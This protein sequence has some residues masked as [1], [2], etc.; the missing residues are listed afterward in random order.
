MNCTFARLQP[1]GLYSPIALITQLK[2]IVSLVLLFR[3]SAG[4]SW[5]FMKKK[6]LPV[7][8]LDADSMPNPIEPRS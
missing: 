8:L 5:P 2:F 3:N 6:D 1:I 4:A 7:S